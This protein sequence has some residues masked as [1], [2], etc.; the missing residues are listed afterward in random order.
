MRCGDRSAGSA[1]DSFKTGCGATAYPHAMSTQTPG[2]VRFDALG[3]ATTDLTASLAFYRRLGLEFPEGAE[4]APHVEAQVA[5]GIRL[6]WDVV[7]AEEAPAGGG[8]PQLAFLCD[9]P[10][11]VDALYAELT[12]A[13]YRGTTPPWDAV[14]GQRYAVVADPDGNGV[15]LFAPLEAS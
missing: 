14:W 7:P 2:R 10:A 6:M 4:R 8:G 1:A 5:G 12:G 13:G 3:I 9:S 15:D 11:G